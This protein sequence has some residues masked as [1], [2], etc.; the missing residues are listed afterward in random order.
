MSHVALLDL[1]K[2]FGRRRRDRPR[3][4]RHRRRRLRLPARTVR[5]REIDAAPASRRIRGPRQ[6]RHPHRWGEHRRPAAQSP[7]DG[8]GLPEPCPLAAYD[9]RAQHRLRP[10]APPAAGGGGAAEDRRRPRPGRTHRAGEALSGRALGRPAAARGDRPLHRAGAEDPAHGRALLQPRYAFAGPPPR[11]GPRHSAA[12]RP[13][14]H[15]RHP[16][17]GGGAHAR[18]YGRRDECRPGRAGR[19]RPP[20]STPTRRPPS[21]PASSAP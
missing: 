18:R 20:R 19:T 10:E 3:H 4:P 1:S 13:D 21:L 15:L 5:L 16:R 17:S 7:A 12:A 8:H 14:H 11:R 2:R 6:R 9:G